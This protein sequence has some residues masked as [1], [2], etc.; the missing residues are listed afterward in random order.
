MD[1]ELGG[2]TFSNFLTNWVKAAKGEYDVILGNV[3]L[4]LYGEYL[5]ARTSP[6]LIEA[7]PVAVGGA[8]PPTRQRSHSQGGV[9]GR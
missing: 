8:Q 5:I 6:T 9:L 7:G 1:I 2:A 4:G 3:R